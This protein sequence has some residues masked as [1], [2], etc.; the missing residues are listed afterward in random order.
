MDGF[1][2]GFPSF[3]LTLVKQKSFFIAVDQGMEPAFGDGVCVY[4]LGL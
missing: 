3:D 4:S 1:I 2:P